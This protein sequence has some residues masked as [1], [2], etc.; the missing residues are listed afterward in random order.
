MSRQES[1]VSD[2]LRW[3]RI[4]MCTSVKGLV[5]VTGPVHMG[6]LHAAEEHGLLWL[7]KVVTLYNELPFVTLV[8]YI[9]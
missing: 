1:I 9:S 3:V 7:H 4:R 2:Q 8:N 6:R 5:Y